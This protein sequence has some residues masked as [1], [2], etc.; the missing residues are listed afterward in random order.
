MA[1]IK[2]ALE[3]A[4]E[5]VEDIQSDPEQI[6]RDQLSKDGKRLAGSFLLDTGKDI[7]EVKAQYGK[8][9]DEDLSIVREALVGTLLSNI[10]L[11]QNEDYVVLLG[12]MRSLVLMICSKEQ[13][14][15]DIFVQIDNLYNQYL[16]TKDQMKDRLIEQYRPQLMQ[17]QQMIEQQTGQHI[18][19]QPE[20]DKDF[21][22]LLY[23][24][25]QRIDDQYN[26]I[27][28]QLQDA[29]KELI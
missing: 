5:R 26:Q 13:K 23:Q 4:M 24:T 12:R 7:E 11:P 3:I 18:D 29:L 1:R 27:I 10:K 20:Q 6:K 8:Y 14:V 9:S 19:I 28:T 17:K 15:T 21:L 2:S 16:S 25:Y 22:D